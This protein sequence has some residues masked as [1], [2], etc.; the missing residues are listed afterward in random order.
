MTTFSTLKGKISSN[1]VLFDCLE[2]QEFAKA[3]ELQP[4]PFPHR[5]GGLRH[6]GSGA[7]RSEH[8]PDNALGELE[9]QPNQ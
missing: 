2:C 3:G 5:R 8:V 6:L 7:G 1:V 9:Q 4:R